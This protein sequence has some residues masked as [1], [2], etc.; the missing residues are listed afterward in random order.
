MLRGA[1]GEPL[2]NV[3]GVKAEVEKTYKAA[4]IAACRST[5]NPVLIA[6]TT[7]AVART[8]DKGGRKDK[9]GAVMSVNGH[10]AFWDPMLGVDGAVMPVGGG[11]FDG[12]LGGEAPEAPRGDAGGRR[13]HVA[14]G[15]ARGAQGGGGAGGTAAGVALVEAEGRAEAEVRRRRPRG[16]GRGGGRRRRERRRVQP[17]PLRRGARGG[18]GAQGGEGGGAGGGARRRDAARAAAEQGRCGELAA[19]A[20]ELA[21]TKSIELAQTT[22]RLQ[23]AQALIERTMTTTPNPT[24]SPPRLA[25]ADEE[26]AD[27]TVAAAAGSCHAAASEARLVSSPS[28]GRRGVARR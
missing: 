23:Q 11:L 4:A 19:R 18:A 27:L 24:M 26:V 7:R 16:V 6:A 10:D 20:E 17:A 3:Q 13:A 22:C 28:F 5:T 1:D 12:G 21:A 25:A 2:R 8:N 15:E 9:E 14:E